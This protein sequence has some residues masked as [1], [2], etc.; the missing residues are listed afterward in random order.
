M[1]VEKDMEVEREDGNFTSIT[2]MP[3]SDPGPQPEMIPAPDSL[4]LSAQLPSPRTS[5]EKRQHLESSVD[6]ACA[7]PQAPRADGAQYDKLTW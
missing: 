1:D 2:G 5:L 3:G 7:P 6:K 4:S